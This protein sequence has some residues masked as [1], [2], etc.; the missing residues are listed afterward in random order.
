MA[1]FEKRFLHFIASCPDCKILNDGNSNPE[2]GIADFLIRG[3]RVVAEL[4]WLATDKLD[5]LQRLGTELI[6]TRD[7]AVME[8]SLS[9]GLSKV[10]RT[11]RR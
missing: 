4:K 1:Q 7:L 5:A 9:I 8:K 3:D 11:V 10:S 6:E 2:G